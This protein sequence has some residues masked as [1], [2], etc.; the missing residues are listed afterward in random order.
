MK[1]IMTMMLGLAFLAGTVGVGFAQDAPKQ[2]PTKAEKRTPEKQNT[3][4]KVEQ[5]A[6]KKNEKNLDPISNKNAKKK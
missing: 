5:Q 2:E 4:K 1:K 6:E 3:K